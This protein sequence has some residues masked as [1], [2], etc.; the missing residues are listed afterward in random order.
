MHCIGPLPLQLAS[1]IDWIKGRLFFIV[2]YNYAR[3]SCTIR[4][5]IARNHANKSSW[6]TSGHEV[7]TTIWN[8][9]YKEVPFNLIL[10]LPCTS[11]YL[12]MVISTLGNTNCFVNSIWDL[13]WIA[14]DNGSNC[15]M[16]IFFLQKL[17]IQWAI[18]LYLIEFPAVARV[19]FFLVLFYQTG[20]LLCSFPSKAAQSEE[21]PLTLT[22]FVA[23][24]F[25]QVS[26][27]KNHVISVSALMS[28]TDALSTLLQIRLN[29]IRSGIP[30]SK[31]A[32]VSWNICYLHMTKSTGSVVSC[33][34]AQKA[35]EIKYLALSRAASFEIDSAYKI[36]WKSQQQ[37][38]LHHC[39]CASCKHFKLHPKI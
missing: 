21:F 1:C 22:K 24:G 5:I 32:M 31:N 4:G 36:G 9:C 20:E 11:P 39:Q 13:L 28:L 6:N 34:V 30:K 25:L 33:S 8:F 7:S 35:Q 27:E 19:Y 17:Q 15:K 29:S 38:I 16:S 10:Y 3:N 23:L 18:F 2:K 26:L 14:E 12:G 37:Q